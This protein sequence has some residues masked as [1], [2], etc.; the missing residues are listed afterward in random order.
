VASCQAP[1]GNKRGLHNGVM[2]KNKKGI[3]RGQRDGQQMQNYG[4]AYEKN[5]QSILTKTKYK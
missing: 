4:N 3:I 1:K 2:Q 5:F